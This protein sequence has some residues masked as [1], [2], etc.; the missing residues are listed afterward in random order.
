MLRGPG[1]GLPASAMSV[2]LMWGLWCVA[3]WQLPS[4]KFTV[5]L[6]LGRRGCGLVKKVQTW[7]SSGAGVVAC[8]G[9]QNGTSFACTRV[10]QL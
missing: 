8:A 9:L 5:Q 4:A 10:I 6:L 7:G 3:A 1:C 2:R